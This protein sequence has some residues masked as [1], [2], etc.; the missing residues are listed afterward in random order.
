MKNYLFMNRIKQVAMLLI[1]ASTFLACNDD[2]NPT[3]D[4]EAIF[5]GQTKSYDL[6]P[7]ANSG[8]SGTAL[9]EET[10]TGNTKLTITLEGTP[11]GGQH[12][13]HIH[14]NSAAVGGGIAI[15]LTPVNGTTGVSETNIMQKDDGTAIKFNDLLSFDGYINVHLSANDLATVVAQGDIGS[16][17]LTGVFKTYD[18]NEAAVAGISGEITFHERMNGF[19][20]A[21]IT[22]A[23][24]PDGGMHPAHIHAN[25]AAIGGGIEFT[26]N[27]VNGTTGLSRTDTRAG[28]MDGEASFTYAEILEVDGYVNV[29]LSAD[30][31]ETIVAQGDIGS[32]E[33]TGESKTYPLN[34]SAVAG[35]SGQIIFQERIN[36]FALAT[37]TLSGTP[38]GGMHPAHIHQ[39]S[40][41][42]GGGILFTFKPVNGTTGMSVSDTRSGMMDN[43]ASYTYAQIL[44]V[45]GYV[46]VHLS[47]AN[48]ATIVAQ[49][50]IGSNFQ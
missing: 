27:P 22:L 39:N 44:T 7:V 38:D 5:T 29:H 8:V 2:N 16:N 42:V 18:L 17:E 3:I 41:A 46:N 43:E 47:A 25:A 36:G 40:A 6:D 14:F 21:T 34:E 26:F 11:D 49:G 35:I 4:P 15:S 28:M 45:D 9:M 12:P 31:L 32:N 48:L 20:L 13:A 23:G 37:I 19:A 10:S 24:T 50:N 33:L 30:D 1:M